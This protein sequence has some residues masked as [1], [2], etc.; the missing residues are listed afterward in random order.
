[1]PEDPQD[2]QPQHIVQMFAPSGA[3]KDVP[4]EK[5]ME[6]KQN[7]FTP[8]VSMNFP[9]GKQKWVPATKV[10]EAAKPE[11]GGKINP[12]EEQSAQHPAW[13]SHVL[14]DLWGMVKGSAQMAPNV[15]DALGGDSGPLG[16]QLLQNARENWQRESTGTDPNN[17][18]YSR[19][20]STPYKVASAVAGLTTP[21]NIP[22]VE[23]SA[24][25]G[26]PGGV[27]A[28][29][30]TAAGMTVGGAA[31]GEHPMFQR[32]MSKMTPE[33]L[34]SVLDDFVNDYK[35]SKLSDQPATAGRV[36]KKLWQD[37]TGEM[38]VPFTGGDKPTI[39]DVANPARDTSVLNQVKQE[40]PEWTLSQ[41][42]QEAAKRV[43]PKKPSPQKQLDPNDEIK[44]ARVDGKL[45]F[46]TRDIEHADWLDELGVDPKN[47]DKIQRGRV[48]FH[49]G[50]AILQ[51]Y[52]HTEFT[53]N[54]VVHAL[55]QRYNNFKDFD[56]VDRVL[57]QLKNPYGGYKNINFYGED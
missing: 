35:G 4:W 28:H 40:H 34:H 54:D 42:L 3:L 49:N 53:P 56:M 47:F 25:E 51:S 32:L 1:M 5:M 18:T 50:K 7:G 30:G 16:D 46:T 14:S 37:Q 57:P 10:L 41:Q 27:M 9:S 39:E 29:A 20:Y 48:Y 26:D 13:Y 15:L 22:G 2:Q 55:H 12:L 24:A 43:N 21:L 31:L 45:R 19:P 38:K 23:Q 11:N 52:G 8:A 33:Q 6:A 17:L 36:L 44:W